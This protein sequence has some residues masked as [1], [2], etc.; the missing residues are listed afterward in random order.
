MIPLPP[1]F[2]RQLERLMP[3]RRTKL[4]AGQSDR[5]FVSATS[6]AGS[7][8]EPSSAYA[9]GSEPSASTRQLARPTSVIW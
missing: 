8:S 4:E 7:I 5:L 6:A 9:R 1:C 3:L 2:A